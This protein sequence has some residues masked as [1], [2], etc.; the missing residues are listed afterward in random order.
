MSVAYEPAKIKKVIYEDTQTV[1]HVKCDGCGKKIYP[2]DSFGDCRCDN[3]YVS[4]IT[5]HNDWGN[6]SFESITQKEYC[7]KCAAE[8]MRKYILEDMPDSTCEFDGKVIKLYKQSNGI[9]ELEAD[10]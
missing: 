4:I 10:Y 5:Q 8:R 9:V 2:A 1:L 3:Q 6:D 7:F